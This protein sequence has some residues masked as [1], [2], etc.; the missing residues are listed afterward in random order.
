LTRIFLYTI[1]S[2]YSRH[3]ALVR[4][5]QIYAKDKQAKDKQAK[6]KQAK[7]LY[8]WMTY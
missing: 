3:R 5:D 8:G 7:A 2:N 1:V 6:D 4:K